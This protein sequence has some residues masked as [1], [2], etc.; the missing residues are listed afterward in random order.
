VWCRIFK[1]EMSALPEP[2]VEEL[3][4]SS[5]EGELTDLIYGNRHHSR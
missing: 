4:S 3:P 1:P 2:V 5:G